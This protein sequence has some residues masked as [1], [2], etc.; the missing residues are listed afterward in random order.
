MTALGTDGLPGGWPFSGTKL[1][2]LLLLACGLVAFGGLLFR[3]TGMV[4]GTPAKEIA[5]G[6]GWSVGHIP[7]IVLG[8]VLIWFCM[9][10]P[11]PFRHLLDGAVKILLSTRGA[12]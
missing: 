8:A 9:T 11:D 5:R 12:A 10:L 3:V 6:E 4:W 2:L 7:I 1:P